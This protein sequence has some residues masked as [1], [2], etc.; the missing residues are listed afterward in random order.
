MRQVTL[1]SSFYTYAALTGGYVD[2]YLTANGYGIVPLTPFPFDTMLYRVD[3]MDVS[4]KLSEGIPITF[5]KKFHKL[6][7]RIGTSTNCQVSTTGTITGD[8]P[9]YP[10]FAILENLR[11]IA[12]P[13]EALTDT[14]YWETLTVEQSGVLYIPRDCDVTFKWKSGS[15]DTPFRMY[16]LQAPAATTSDV[17][18][19]P[20]QSIVT[21]DLQAFR[22]KVEKGYYYLSMVD[23]AEQDM[24][25]GINF[26]GVER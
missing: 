20:Y 5:E 2:F 6:H 15:G 26:G 17:F 22:I 21:S 16:R 25:I 23:P 24:W 12:N 14:I 18:Y 8:F 4:I 13:P 19:A 10:K 7:F 9:L 11:D 1:A 3:D